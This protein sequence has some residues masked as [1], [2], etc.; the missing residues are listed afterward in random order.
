MAQAA[1]DYADPVR[2]IT[3]SDKEIHLEVGITR[4]SA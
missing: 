4:R 2:P 1:S 3:A